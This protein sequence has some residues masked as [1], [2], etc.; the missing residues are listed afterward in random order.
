L[1]YIFL[2]E[3]GCLGFNFTKKK[4]SKF[5]VI[6][7]LFV[8]DERKRSLE[9]IIRKIYEGFT[10][11][12]LKKRSNCLHCYK[13]KPATRIKLLNMLNSKNSAIMAIY[14]DKKKVYSRLH[15]EKQVLYNYITNI[16]LDRIFTKKLIPKE[17][18]KQIILVASRRETNQALNENFKYYLENQVNKNHAAKIE[19]EIKPPHTEK[20]L[21]LVDFVSWAIF[22]KYEHGDDFYANLIKSSIVEEKS[23]FN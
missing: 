16:L 15:D 1:G 21:Q 7:F 23:L 20:C 17:D 14:L 5:F 4:T 2:D 10:A 9:K 12:E 19:V 18:S 3:S 11:K 6:S 8:R 13:E 22:R